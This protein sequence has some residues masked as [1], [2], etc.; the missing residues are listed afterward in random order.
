MDVERTFR[1]FHWPRLHRHD[2]SRKIYRV[3][4]WEKYLPRDASEASDSS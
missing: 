1:C 2:L 3:Q 4:G